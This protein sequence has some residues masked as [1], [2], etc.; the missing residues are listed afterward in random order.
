MCYPCRNCG[1]CLADPS[2]AAVRCPRCGELLP[3]DARA[4]AACGW[5]R[6]AAP[7]VA[8]PGTAPG[9]PASRVDGPSEGL[10]C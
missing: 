8:V 6:P 5:T 3:A 4:C 7:A 10:G 9:R 1:S 2:L